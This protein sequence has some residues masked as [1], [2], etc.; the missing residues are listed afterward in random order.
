M[1]R[2]IVAVLVGYLVMAILIFSGTAVHFVLLFG[3]LPTATTHLQPPLS[4][5]VFNLI[6]SSIFAAFGGWVCATIVTQKRFKH[7]LILAGLVFVL[8]LVSVYIDRGQQPVWYQAGL[9]LLGAPA[10][11]VGAWLQALRHM[12]A[13]MA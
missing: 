12:P 8:S 9:V 11:A 10:T 7:G 4:F 5:G 3:K 2:S 6:Y 1:A 13:A